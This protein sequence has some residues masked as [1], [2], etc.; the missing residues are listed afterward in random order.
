MT[1]Q[2][3]EPARAE[4][5]FL[6][7]GMHCASCVAR[8]EKGLARLPGVAGAS[9]NLATREARVAFDPS[10]VSPEAI[11]ARVAQLGY[12][13]HD[14]PAPADTSVPAADT[15]HARRLIVA[16]VLTAPVFVISMFH[17]R[18]PGSELLMLALTTPVVMWAG[19]EFFVGAWRGL[20]RGSADMN[21]LIAVGTGTAYVTSAVATL[22]PGLFYE[23][24]GA[25]QH[26]YF[27]AAAMITTLILLGRHLEDRARA[28]TTTAITR[29][30][31]REP[32]TAV[33][34][35]D[36]TGREVPVDQ[37]AA[38]DIVVIRPGAR[39]PVDGEIVDGASELDESLVTG[40]P[41]PVPRG[42]GDTVLAGTVNTTG[43]FRF[44]ATRVGRDTTLRQIVR[45]VQE[46]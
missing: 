10:A 44:L 28:R 14:L 29:L 1:K 25:H 2:N 35:R 18:F 38:G 20:K 13:A 27:E 42:P 21:T 3:P 5:A 30:L 32:P 4:E 8:I 43:A 34:E 12:T 24:G 37:V 15:P 11:R 23:A 19:A 31:E 7:E 46:A 26:V 41:L 17:L 40:E 36:G 16:A 22:A 45:L 9:V 39:V 33:V 6:I